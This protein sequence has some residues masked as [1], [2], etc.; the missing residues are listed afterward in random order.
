MRCSE[1]EAR[2]A[3]YADDALP[4][5]EREQLAA[6]LRECGHC[7][8][9]LESL[10]RSL[11]VLNSA[12]PRVAPDLWSRFQSQVLSSASQSREHPS[13]SC[14][15]ARGL[16]PAS[17]DGE[18]EPDKRATLAA[19]LKQCAECA[20]EEAL[21]MRSVR[22][23][24][25]ANP[26][27]HP[28]PGPEQPDLWSGLSRR[29]AEEIS[30]RDLDALLPAYLEGELTG[31]RATAARCHI[32]TCAACATEVARTRRSLEALVRVG[33]TTPVVDLWP[34]FAKRLEQE[35]AAGSKRQGWALFPSGWDVPRLLGRPLLRPALGVAALALGVL[36]LRS[37]AYAPAP[38]T[39][40]TQIARTAPVDAP[41][42]GL[43][44][45]ASN[46]EDTRR[47]AA[48]LDVEGAESARRSASRERIS[49]GAPRGNTRAVRSRT[50]AIRRVRRGVRSERRLPARQKREAI[51]GKTLLA[52]Q[53][54][55][56]TSSPSSSTRKQ[57][58]SWSGQ[59]EVAF[60]PD[61]G[62]AGDAPASP[63]GGSELVS[64][65][66]DVRQMK[67]EMVVLTQI[68]NEMREVTASPLGTGHNA[69]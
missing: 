51:V 32:E 24:E 55:P 50:G 4:A 20:A 13:V 47:R 16:L 58:A 68:V 1:V 7:R 48:Q 25:T 54:K 23:L 22:A 42:S 66:A 64:A 3:Q 21:L 31:A 8:Q 28:A 45:E 11:G 36:L 10:Q 59:F 39:K 40:A 63:S 67:Q 19:H 17:V 14:R 60:N 69:E 18:M 46:A 38:A 2:L 9:E 34:T 41:S 43:D 15:Q 57:R 27:A 30:C 5:R 37:P 33:A 26:G 12:A 53:P 49:S 52:A 6:H 61:L 65:A 35:Q 44:P 29:L 62:P 56:V